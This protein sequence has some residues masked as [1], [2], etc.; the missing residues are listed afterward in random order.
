[1]LTYKSKDKTLELSG[2]N[3]KGEEVRVSFSKG[4]Y[5]T[6]DDDEVALLDACATD[7]THPIAFDQKEA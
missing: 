4:S 7:P 2:T 6:N 1:M 5:T 3:S